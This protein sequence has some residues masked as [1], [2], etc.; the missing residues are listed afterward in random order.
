M[1]QKAAQFGVGAIAVRDVRLIGEVD[2]VLP[3]Q[4]RAKMLKDGQATE[5]G[6]EDSED[7]DAFRSALRRAY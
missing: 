4:R 6:V 2:D 5:S 1:R 7:G 3:R